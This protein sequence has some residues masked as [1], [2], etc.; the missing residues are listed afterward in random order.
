MGLGRGWG[1]GLGGLGGGW[2]GGGVQGPQEKW[3]CKILSTVATFIHSIKSHA[4]GTVLGA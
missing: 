4:P 1:G 2:G 3:A